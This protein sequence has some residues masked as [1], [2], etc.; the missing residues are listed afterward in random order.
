MNYGWTEGFKVKNKVKLAR[1]GWGEVY[2][3]L[4]TYDVCLNFGVM[5]SL[6]PLS[7]PIPRDHPF[8]GQKLANPTPLPLSAD[9]TCTCPL[10]IE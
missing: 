6:S 7:V 2:K 1:G 10:T 5:D 8:V 4:F 9:V 3:G